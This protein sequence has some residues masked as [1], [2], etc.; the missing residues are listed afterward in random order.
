M[1]IKNDMMFNFNILQSQSIQIMKQLSLLFLFTVFWSTVNCQYLRTPSE[2]YKLANESS[3][4]YLSDTSSAEMIG[5]EYT[6]LKDIY[7]K[8]ENDSLRIIT[9][10]TNKKSEKY[11][12]KAHKFEKNRKFH[13]AASFLEKAYKKDTYNSKLIKELGN[14]VGKTGELRDAIKLYERV[15]ESTP[16]DYEAHHAISAL[17]EE[18][19]DHEKSI[20]HMLLAHLYNRNSEPI[21][22][23]LKTL[24]TR[25]NKKYYTA[26]FQPEYNITKPSDSLVLIKTVDS[27]WHS[28]AYCK[29]VWAF[30]NEYRTKKS[31]MSD[32]AIEIIE[33]KECLLCSLITY[34]ETKSEHQKIPAMKKLS[35]ALLTQKIDQFLLYEHLLKNNPKMVYQLDKETIDK[36]K[37]Y[38]ID[39]KRNN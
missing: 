20:D 19:G 35:K 22:D 15:L 32:Q 25:N 24:L 23:S 16:F 27:T 34:E 5:I 10:K 11:L 12:R 31:P 8:D 21:L 33:E 9:F 6:T 29:A 13:K 3:I 1:Y 7:L 4:N 18:K 30:E 39:P 28:Y 38:I 2:I 26:N 37:T 36:L 14:L 17:F